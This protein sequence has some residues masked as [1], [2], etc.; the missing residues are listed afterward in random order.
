MSKFKVSNYDFQLGRE[1]KGKNNSSETKKKSQDLSHSSM[2]YSQISV[3]PWYFMATDIST[4]IES[5]SKSIS[6]ASTISVSHS[7][8]TQHKQ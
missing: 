1:K 7:T 6:T 3:V 8:F 5:P 2:I 4:P